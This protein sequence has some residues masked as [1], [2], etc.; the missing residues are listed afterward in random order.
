MMHLSRDLHL[1]I[2]NVETDDARKKSAQDEAVSLG[3]QSSLVSAVTPKEIVN[4]DELYVSE[5]VHAVWLS[6][7][8]AMNI[9]LKTKEEFAIISEDDFKIIDRAKLLKK[10]TLCVNSNFDYV[11]F[12][13]L[14]PGIDTRINIYST[15]IQQLGFKFL[16]YFSKS[17]LLRKIINFDRMRIREADGLPA[18]L[19][20]SNSQPGAHF[21]LVSRK[22]AEAIQGLNSPQFLSIDDF[23]SSLAKMRAFKMVRVRKSLVG[24]KDFP[25]WS[26]SRFR[27]K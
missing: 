26:G 8:K 2:I 5:G 24:Q 9:F 22:F 20:L 12:G 18:G 6:H 17:P 1:Y 13:Y 27:E 21:Y 3:I 14:R 7:M 4:P 16:C 25:S 15:N 23:Y 11:Q 19:V 10:L